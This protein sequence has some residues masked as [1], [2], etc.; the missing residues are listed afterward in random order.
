MNSQPY[1]VWFQFTQWFQRGRMKW[2]FFTDNDEQMLNDDKI[3]HER[4]GQGRAKKERDN[5]ICVNLLWTSYTWCIKHIDECVLLSSINTN[6]QMQVYFFVKT[7]FVTTTI[8]QTQSYEF[9][10]FMNIKKM[11][12][13]KL[14]STNWYKTL[15]PSFQQNIYFHNW[16]T[17][18]VKE[19]ENSRWEKKWYGVKQA[20]KHTVYMVLHCNIEWISWCIHMFRLLP[21]LSTLSL[22]MSPGHI[23]FFFIWKIIF[24]FYI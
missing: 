23:F 6:Q 10:L 17:W 24:D 5:H 7:F 20:S 11:M 4:L 3:S 18:I 2:K 14:A 15:S 19:K 16:F 12:Y 9:H 1:Q 8:Y 22:S 21:M 13:L